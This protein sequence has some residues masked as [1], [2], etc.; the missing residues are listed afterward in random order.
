M[1]YLSNVY[2]LIAVA[3]LVYIMSGAL[4][5]LKNLLPGVKGVQI[6]LPILFVLLTHYTPREIISAFR[7]AGKKS[8]G[9]KNE[10]K[11]AVQFFQTAQYLFLTVMG[12]GVIVLIVWFL[13]S[14]PNSRHIAHPVNIMITFLFF[15]LVFVMFFCIPFRSAVKKKMNEL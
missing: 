3:L 10:Y 14:G 9:E 2:Y 8:R 7:L 1:K 11:N 5:F 4:P 15:P 13:G 6:V 12:I